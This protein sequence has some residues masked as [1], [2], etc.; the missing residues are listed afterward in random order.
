ME[1]SRITPENIESSDLGFRLG[2]RINA[3]GRLAHAGIGG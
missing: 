1:V 3:R 2:P